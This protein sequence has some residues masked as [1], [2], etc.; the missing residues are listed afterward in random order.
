MDEKVKFSFDDD[1]KIRVLE[2][3]KFARSE[4][5]YK[6]CNNFNDK[7]NT[8]REKTK[9]LVEILEAHATKIDNQK[10]RVSFCRV[11]ILLIFNADHLPL[12]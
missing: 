1:F 4:E 6:E 5:F 7:V 8:F 2:Q 11:F 3:Q 9:A 10:L 12:L